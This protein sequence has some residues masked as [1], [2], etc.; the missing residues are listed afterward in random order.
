MGSEMCIRDRASPQRK[1]ESIK[2]YRTRITTAVQ[3]VQ[4]RVSEKRD[5][6]HPRTCRAYGVYADGLDADMQK[7]VFNR[8]K[9]DDMDI[10]NTIC[11]DA[12]IAIDRIATA[13]RYALIDGIVA[14]L[15]KTN[16][17]PELRQRAEIAYAQHDGKLE[18][19]CKDCL[20]YTSPSPR[21]LSTSRMPSSA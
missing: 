3:T 14:V 17:A 5:F 11:Q 21:D 4:T 16:C 8:F 13:E 18:E 20:L 12:Q 2:D 15:I 9:T 6:N 7:I 1:T 10:Y 19:L